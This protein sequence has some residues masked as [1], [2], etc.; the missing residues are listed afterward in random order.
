MPVGWRGPFAAWLSRAG[1]H[2][3]RSLLRRLPEPAS[4]RNGLTVFRSR[5]LF[6]DGTKLERN[7][8]TECAFKPALRCRPARK[9]F[10]DGSLPGPCQR[11]QTAASIVLLERA[12]KVP[13]RRAIHDQQPCEILDRTRTD[14][15]Q[16]RQ[17]RKLVHAQPGGRERNRHKVSSRAALPGEARRN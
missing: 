1:K 12:Q 17:D 11:H 15:A 7:L 8:F 4:L 6:K 13:Q 9:S 3:S 5:N 14:E 10:V 16:P 2:T